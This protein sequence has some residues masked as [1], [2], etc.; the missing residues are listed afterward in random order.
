MKN[1]TLTGARLIGMA[2]VSFALA[3][4]TPGRNTPEKSLFTDNFNSGASPLWGNEVGSWSA[5]GGVYRATLPANFP[6]AFSSLPFNLTDFSVDFDI[7]DVSDG[8]IW[9][10]STPAPGTAVGV[11]GILVNFQAIQGTHLYWHEVTDGNNWGPGRDITF[12]SFGFNPHVHIEVSG[13]RYAVFLNGSAEAALTFTNSLFSSGRV[14]LYDFSGQSFDNFSLEGKAKFSHG[15]DAEAH[16]PRGNAGWD[17]TVEVRPTA[18]EKAQAQAVGTPANLFGFTITGTNNQV[19]VVEACTNLADPVWI[20]VGTNIL[21]GG[22]SYFSDPQWTKY[23]GRF[24]RLR[25]P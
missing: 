17:L 21:T 24:Y 8:G 19:V 5:A 25:T 10:R 23:P 15:D 14:A 18:P 12:L 22:S 7:N 4:N 3:A 13:D 16:H 11:K 20:P 1:L 6:A 9:L 2:A